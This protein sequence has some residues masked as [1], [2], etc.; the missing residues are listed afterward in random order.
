MTFEE[1]QAQTLLVS[2]R[3][4]FLALMHC[5]H[6]PV[7][8]F[9]EVFAQI[10]RS[11]ERSCCKS[12]LATFSFLFFPSSLSSG[13]ECICFGRTRLAIGSCSST[14]NSSLPPKTLHGLFSWLTQLYQLRGTKQ[15]IDQ[16][17]PEGLKT[18][19]IL[20]IRKKLFVNCLL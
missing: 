15:L 20:S 6:S 9:P 7:E 4:A 10:Q 11:K 1:K 17:K 3:Q 5:M 12:Q 18:S 14:D 13:T 8:P 2:C 16:V 19:I